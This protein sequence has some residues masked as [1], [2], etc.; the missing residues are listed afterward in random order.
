VPLEP[1]PALFIGLF[2]WLVS[3]LIYFLGYRRIAHR[4]DIISEVPTVQARDIPGLGA[5]MVEVKGLIRCPRP[6]TSDLAR[7]PCV[8]FEAS[9]TEHWTT[10]R[11]R[12][13][14]KATGAPSPTAI[15]KRATKTSHMSPSTYRT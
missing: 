4:F 3:A 10:T 9:V 13:I 5:A 12:R 1:Q 2:C 8:A 11:Q 14:R 15:P 7:V 6:L